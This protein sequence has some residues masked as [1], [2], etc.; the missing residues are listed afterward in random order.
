MVPLRYEGSISALKGPKPGAYLTGTR[1]NQP[2]ISKEKSFYMFQPSE[3]C[4][5]DIIGYLRSK[6][7]SPVEPAAIVAPPTKSALELGGGC[8]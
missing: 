4:V 1:I 5:Q 8:E 7:H 2:S 3:E 6:R